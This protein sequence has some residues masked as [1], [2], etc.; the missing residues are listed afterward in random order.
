VN[1][2]AQNAPFRQR[3]V[4]AKIG[5]IDIGLRHGNSFR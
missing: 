4:L 2:A 5:K 3:R 1:R